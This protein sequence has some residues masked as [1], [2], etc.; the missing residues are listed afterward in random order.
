MGGEW[1]QQA[2]ADARSG[3][4]ARNK[5][6]IAAWLFL[7][8]ARVFFAIYVVIPIFESLWLRL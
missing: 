8:R 5:L 1:G 7:S 2:R 4:A 3:G 6:A